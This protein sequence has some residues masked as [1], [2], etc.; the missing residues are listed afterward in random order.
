MN[1]LSK[2]Q[3]RRIIALPLQPPNPTT[4]HLE[5]KPTKDGSYTIYSNQYTSTFHSIFGARTES[6]WIFLSYGLKP[7]VSISSLNVLEIGFGTGMNALITAEYALKYQVLIHYITIDKHP[8]P[9]QLALEFV[10]LSAQTEVE[11]QL[12]RQLHLLSWNHRHSLHPYFFFTKIHLDLI[13]DKL[14][15]QPVID[16]VYYDAFSPFTQKDMWS[17][18]TLAKVSNLMK[19]GGTLVTYSVQGNFRRILKDLNFEV[20]KHPGPPGKREILRAVKI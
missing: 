3:L 20:E 12:W 6:E 14:N 15:F 8:L 4:D 1:W 2:L 13:L 11:D 9:I 7:L 19:S 18:D 5:I 16:L 10:R 17:R